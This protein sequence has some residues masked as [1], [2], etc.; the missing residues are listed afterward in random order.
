MPSLA[1]CLPVLDSA[2]HRTTWLDV[3]ITDAG[4]VELRDPDDPAAGPQHLW[5]SHTLFVQQAVLGSFLGDRDF[6]FIYE[7]RP[8]PNVR[9]HPFDARLDS[10]H[11]HYLLVDDGSAGEFGAE[12][13]F[14]TDLVR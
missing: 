5:A 4:A 12:I 10:N 11:T 13:G 8:T 2:R 7:G 3:H 9:D 6:P 14:R 1:A